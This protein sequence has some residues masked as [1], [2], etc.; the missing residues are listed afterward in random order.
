MSNMNN[1]DQT[2][3]EL[4]AKAEEFK[5]DNILLKKDIELLNVKL[6]FARYINF[7]LGGVGVVLLGL[8]VFLL[9]R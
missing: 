4:Q 2:L 8:V 9:V 1:L 3:N 6:K 5:I 7:T